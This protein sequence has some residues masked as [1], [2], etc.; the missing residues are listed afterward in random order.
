MGRPIYSFEFEIEMDHVPYT[1]LAEGN[2]YK[3]LVGDAQYNYKHSDNGNN[4]R[5]IDELPT[6]KYEECCQHIAG[7]IGDR[8]DQARECYL[9]D[10]ADARRKYGAEA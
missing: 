2:S 8:I 4:F 1:V 9:E 6:H 3:E 10:Q 5:S 7:E